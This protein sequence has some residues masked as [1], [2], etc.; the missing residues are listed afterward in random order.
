[1]NSEEL[2]AKLLDGAS[3]KTVMIPDVSIES[4]RP[5]HLECFQL[6]HIIIKGNLFWGMSRNAH[7]HHL[8]GA[9]VSP[10]GSSFIYGNSP[11]RVFFSF[12]LLPEGLTGMPLE[13]Y[14]FHR[15][16]CH[17]NYELVW[18]SQSQSSADNVRACTEEGKAIKIAMLDEDNIWNIHP[19]DLPM[20]HV[21][22]GGFLIK[23]ELFPYP[24]VLRDERQTRVLLD[25]FKSAFRESPGQTI[26]AVTTEPFYSFYGLYED[27]TYYNSF[28]IVRN[29]RKKYRR[30]RIFAEI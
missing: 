29:T 18:D 21:E 30:L 16:V 22:T 25:T 12:N 28:D 20:F 3:L 23:T 13:R 27:G 11:D 17:R 6:P 14:E 9:F 26:F 8:L 5:K 2:V 10:Y 1:M 19:V 4:N 15:F 7:C 24:G